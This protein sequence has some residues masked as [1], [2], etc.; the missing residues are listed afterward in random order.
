MDCLLAPKLE[1]TIVSLK[2]LLIKDST[3]DAN[4]WICR[5][6]FK[7]F[8]NTC[9]DTQYSRTISF[10]A[11]RMMAATNGPH[12]VAS[13]RVINETTSEQLVWAPI[14]WYYIEL[15]PV[16]SGV[17]CFN[18]TK[19]VDPLWLWLISNSVQSPEEPV[20]NIVT[21]KNVVVTVV[22]V[23]DSGSVET[24]LDE[25]IYSVHG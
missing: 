23:T 8:T 24:I 5:C 20:H 7:W 12:C 18:V 25:M 10:V 19:L 22:L 11:T 4:Y 9:N 13:C 6:A 14:P 3:K 17:A 2:P 21:L 16:C 1:K 15:R